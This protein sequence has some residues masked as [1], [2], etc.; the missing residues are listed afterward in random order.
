M[1]PQHRWACCLRWPHGRK[2][3]DIEAFQHA[4]AGYEMLP[5]RALP[6]AA[7]LIPLAELAAAA[8][9]LHGA[10]RVA[11][12]TL[13]L[14]V[15][16]V[17]TF[18][19]VHSLRAGRSELECGCGGGEGV[20]LSWALVARNAVLAA[21]AVLAMLSPQERPTTALDAA[22]GVLATLAVLGLYAVGNQLLANGPRLKKLRDAP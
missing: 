18:A 19:G 3:R 22:T 15:L 9:L 13:A 1:L 21:I 20:T 2:L 10:T 12:A 16:L 11:G 4:M 5:Q 7:R 14:L 17:F 8:L 6:L